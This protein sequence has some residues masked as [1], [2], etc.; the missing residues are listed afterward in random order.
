MGVYVEQKICC[1]T[2]VIPK[3]TGQQNEINCLKEGFVVGC[4]KHSNEPS[5]LL[6][7]T[8]YH[9]VL[10]TVTEICTFNCA[11]NLNMKHGVVTFPL[12]F[13]LKKVF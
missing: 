4:C 8:L 3:H 13:I 12:Q 2:G 10:M 1:P 11:D 5:G 6:K 9:V 7:K